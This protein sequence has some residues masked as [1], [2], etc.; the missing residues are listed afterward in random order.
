MGN[1]GRGNVQPG[2]EVASV[3]DKA[4]ISDVKIKAP[5]IGS[6][7]VVTRFSDVFPL[8]LPGMPSDRDVDFCI[9]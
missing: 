6:N 3:D 2:R 5:S 1:R 4:H 7:S 8:D 9:D